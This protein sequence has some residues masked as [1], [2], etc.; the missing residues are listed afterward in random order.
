MMAVTFSG[1]CM[2]SVGFM[3]VIKGNKE[4]GCVLCMTGALII[5]A[6]LSHQIGVWSRALASQ[7]VLTVPPPQR[8]LLSFRV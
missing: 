1:G 5:F 3:Q 7:K 6:G 8:D 2:F 4:F